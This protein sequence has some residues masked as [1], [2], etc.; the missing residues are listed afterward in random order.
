[1]ANRRRECKWCKK[2]SEEFITVPAGT[3]CGMDHAIEFANDST[4]KKQKRLAAKKHKDDRKIHKADKDRVKKI[5]K[6]Y[7]QLQTLVNQCVVH[8]R[9]KGKACCTCGT[10]N[11][12]KYD[13]GHWQTRGA[14]SELRFNLYNIHKQCNQKCNVYASG[15]KQEHEEYISSTYGNH[16]VDWLKSR[17]HPSLK[18]VFPH[19]SD[20]KKE[21]ARYRKIL[22][23]NGLRPNC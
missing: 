10:T 9:D 20:V 14:R 16:V 19:Y 2:Y 12:I 23:D 22:R 1:M 5:S 7:D 18:E 15:A 21:M 6:W 4:T 11:P 13:A 3:F 17:H 8:V